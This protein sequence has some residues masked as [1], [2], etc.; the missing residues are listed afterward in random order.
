MA[1]L[2]NGLGG[3]NGFGEDVLARSDDGESSSINLSSIFPGGINFFG[4]IYTDIFVGNNGG[5]SFGT[6]NVPFAPVFSTFTANPLIL[7]LGHDVDTRN[8]DPVSFNAAG[9]STGSNRVYWDLNPAG[10][11]TFTVTWDD[12]GHYDEE[13]GAPNAFQLQLVGQGGG[14][15]DIVFRY[16]DVLTANASGDPAAAVGYTAGDGEN[17]FALPAS[18]N[19][20]AVLALETAPGNTGVAGLWVFSIVASNFGTAGNDVITG[21]AGD[22]GIFGFGGNDTLSGGGGND[23]LNGGGGDD[24]LNG[25]A[26]NDT[27]NGGANNDL[28]NGGAG[29]DTLNGGAGND[30]LNGGDGNDT[31]VGGYGVDALNGGNG[32]D[33]ADYSFLSTSVTINLAAGTVTGA[34]S[35]TLTSIENATGGT[36]GDLFIGTNGNN[37]LN[38]LGGNNDTV[39]YAAGGR[40]VTANLATGVARGDGNDTLISI[41]RLTGGIRNDVFT[42]TEDDNLLIGGAGRDRLDGGGGGDDLDGGAGDD[43]LFGGDGNDWLTGGAG[44]D[45]LNGGNHDD[46]LDGGSGRDQLSGGDGD[47]SLDG[48]NDTDVDVLQGGRGNDIYNN[49]RSNDRVSES[50]NSGYDTVHAIEN[51]ALAPGSEVEILNLLGAVVSGTGSNTG[52]TIFGNDAA[53]VISGRGGNDN[54]YGSYGDDILNGDAGDDNLY[55]YYDDDTLNGGAGD[56]Y[57]YGEYDED[58]L[59]GG[60]GDDRVFGGDGSDIVR[61]GDGNDLVKVGGQYGGPDYGESEQA[62][63]DAGNDNLSAHGTGGDTLTGGS[64]SDL[65]LFNEVWG[66]S[67][68]HIVT[69]FQ[70]GADQ[71]GLQFV[72]FNGNFAAWFASRGA[73]VGG[74]VVLTLDSGDTVTLMGLTSVSQLDAGDLGLVYIGGTSG[75][76]TLTGANNELVLFG[77]EGDSIYGGDGDDVISGLGGDDDLDGGWGN[78]TLNGGDGEDGLFGYYGDDILNGGAGDDNLNGSYDDDT[79]NGG[80]GEDNLIGG[81]GDDTLDGGAGDDDLFGGEGSDTLNGGAGNDDLYSG[82]GND[83][84]NGGDGDDHLFAEGSGSH[85]LTG[86]AGADQFDFTNIDWSPTEIV[87]DFQNGVD[88]L[89]FSGEGGLANF[90]AAATLDG[91]GFVVLHLNGGGTVELHGMT[92]LAQLDASD[93]QSFN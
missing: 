56:D 55:G 7:A 65:F 4:T 84:L 54:L 68:S 86:G 24:T 35:E 2:I 9:N 83:I 17:F 21:G 74:N 11:G 88:Q 19:A 48:G 26:G 71:L 33:T 50:G 16:E 93:F 23:T 32:T 81:D 42:G 41:E 90:I 89:S 82:S 62:F 70:N 27:L 36:M 66:G 80:D 34:E 64:G 47:D 76:D 40:A 92:S 57:L 37:V 20:T 87:T 69:D 6:A 52:N 59:N 61:G 77:G 14:N 28:L 78:D 63:G 25:D 39:D 38:G 12:V 46:E 30:M 85:T 8:T 91:G 15:Y 31:L 13:N 60:A 44:N 43:S 3:S 45:S 10:N 72:N 49:V 75:N 79:L 73:V 18:G 53:N 67:G 1:N 5:V 51:Y 29:N 22:D 58:T